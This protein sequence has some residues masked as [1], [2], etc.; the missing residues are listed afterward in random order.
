[1]EVVGRRSHCRELV[2]ELLCD[3]GVLVEFQCS[4]VKMVVELGIIDMQLVWA[5]AD[6]GTYGFGVQL[7]ISST[8]F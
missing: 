6:N 1:M 5:D 4:A 2:S 7:S 3:P 8:Q